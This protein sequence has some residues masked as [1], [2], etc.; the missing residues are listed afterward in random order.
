M[1]HA[2]LLVGALIIAVL[3]T[4]SL[5]GAS[6]AD[7]QQIVLKEHL[8]QTWTQELLTYPF[9]A[10]EGACHPDSLRL[11]GPDGPLPVQLSDLVMWPE[12]RTVKAGVVSFITD[13][14]P[15]ETKTFTLT[16]G[17]AAPA[18]PGPR[19]DL[20]VTAGET[21]VD[22]STALIQAQLLLGEKTYDPPVAAAE[23]PGPVVHMALPNGTQYS[24]SRLFGPTPIASYQA[25]LTDNGGVFARV[26]YLYTYADGNT[27]KLTAQISAGD[28]GILWDTEVKEDRP[29]DGVDFLLS[30]GLPTL[31]FPVHMEWFTKRQVFLDNKSAVGDLVELP[32]DTYNE[33]VV[34]KLTPW[35][36]WWDDYTQLLIPLKIAGTDTELQILSRDPGAWVEPAAPGTMRDWGAWQHKLINVER[37]DDGE[38]YLR[39][40]NA[41]GIRRWTVRQVSS[42]PGDATFNWWERGIGKEPLNVVKDYALDWPEQPNSHPRLFVSRERLQEYFATAPHDEKQIQWIVG[43]KPEIRT[44]PSYKDSWALEAWLRSGGKAELAT[45]LELAERLRRHLNLLGKFDTMRSTGIVAALYDALID[46]DL[47]PAEERPL[48][49]AQM[50]YL[51]YKINDP[52]TWSIERGYRS[53]NENMSVSHM[54]ARGILA[55]LLPDHPM[56]ETWVQ[57]AIARMKQWMADV[58]PEGEWSEG[59]HY[60]QVTYSTMIWFAL[61][62]QRAGF[63][64]FSQDPAFL[65]FGMYIAKQQTPLDPQRGQRRVSPPLGR[66]Q[67]GEVWGHLGLLAAL[68]RETQPEYSRI[69]QWGWAQGGYDMK[70]MDARLSG[71]EVVVLDPNQPMEPPTWGSDWFP[72]VGAILRNGVGTEDENYVNLLTNSRAAFARVSEPGGLLKWFAKGRPIAGLFCPGYSERQE[73]LTSR[74]LRARTWKPGDN[75]FLP[76][77]NATTTGENSHAF[78]ARADYVDTTYAIGAPY[79]ANWWAT[80]TPPNLT[81]WPPV[82]Q[83]GQVPFNWRRQV[84]FVKDDDP[85]GPN[86]LIFR[87]TITGGQP[88]LWQMWTLSEKLGTPE[89]AA[90]VE[91]FLA[92]KPGLQAVPPR[93][94]TGDRFT[95]LGQLDLDLEYYLAAPTGTPRWTLRWGTHYQ[96]YGMVGDEYQDLLQVQMPGDGAYFVAMYPRLRTE[97]VPTFATLGDGKVI[98]ITADWGTDYAFLSGSEAAAQAEGA[99]FRGTAACVQDRQTG[100]VLALNAA[101]EVAYKGFGVTAEQP[102]SLRA[103]ETAGAV[104][105]PA[106]HAEM[107][108][109]LTLPGNWQP[110]QPAAGVKWERLDEGKYRLT[111]PA[112]A[113]QV[114]IVQG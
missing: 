12:G 24:G 39:V 28:C 64:D 48:F 97:A 93:P 114:R 89:E 5:G 71:F 94:L 87:D 25:R 110:A 32:L 7:E 34:T 11:T 42:R 52:S 109:T 31:T 90:D 50:A 80:Y 45:E 36:D 56:A 44:E 83:E 84:L 47:I 10:P 69:M 82:A 6:M 77:G 22:L 85:A 65:K 58:G 17:T 14:A 103:L 62:A 23:V 75:W 9:S 57:P 38:V 15:L 76:F 106:D 91:A 49:R 112:G 27:L 51:A 59:G 81:E 70:I 101:G 95:A 55:C 54:L 20:A 111:L 2:S 37:A 53:Y 33:R 107:Q 60:D 13:L 21:A 29:N 43:Q 19:G 74:V 96:D 100:M 46:T 4:L 68:T 66:A 67:G 99:R 26:E 35:N 63:Y 98:K 61:A 86:Y 16:Y 40:N 102:V 78:L 104:N 88:T 108:V 8:G 79:D 113:T 1:P 41:Q 92:D 72:A 18:A 3:L 105:A 30:A 73:L